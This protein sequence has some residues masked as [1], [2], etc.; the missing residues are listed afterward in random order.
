ME[1]ENFNSWTVK[2]LK[3]YLLQYDIKPSSLK[4]S[5]KNG[6]V[7]KKDFIKA[8][9]KIGEKS[10]IIKTEKIDRIDF[11]LP[12]EEDLITEVYNNCRIYDKLT[13]CKTNKKYN[14][15][16]KH[17]KDINTY[18]FNLH[19]RITKDISHNYIY[20]IYNN[21]LYLTRTK[22][23]EIPL[24]DGIIPISVAATHE[25]IVILTKDGDL[26]GKGSSTIVIV[27]L[28]FPW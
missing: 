26:Y 18:K 25:S 17:D 21:K 12:L 19:Q 14:N 11:V 4:G 15:L 3:E 10:D 20:T 5:G 9:K 7:I 24:P 8:A 13:L 28:P 23:V 1:E 27:L 6:G 2:D 16:C 22:M